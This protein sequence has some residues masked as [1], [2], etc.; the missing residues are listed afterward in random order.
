MLAYLEVLI[1]CKQVSV[2]HSTAKKMWCSELQGYQRVV[3]DWQVRSLV[4][5]PADHQ[6]T[7]LFPPCS[8][9]SPTGC[10]SLTRE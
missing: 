2:L 5:D 4:L 8:A 7:C 1:H 9:G 10:S 6:L 3:E